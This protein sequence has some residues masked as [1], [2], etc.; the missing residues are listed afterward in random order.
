M[1]YIM[2]TACNHFLK[3]EVRGSPTHSQQ[4]VFVLFPCLWQVNLTD[5]QQFYIKFNSFLFRLHYAAQRE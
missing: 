4:T 2:V 3:T 1:S 5:G